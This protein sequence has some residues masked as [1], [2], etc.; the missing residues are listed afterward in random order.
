MDGGEEIHLLTEKRTSC[1]ETAPQ[2]VLSSVGQ[3]VAFLLMLVP[4]LRRQSN[5]TNPTDRP[6]LCR[7]LSSRL[8][9]LKF[10]SLLSNNVYRWETQITSLSTIVVDVDMGSWL[11]DWWFVC[12]THDRKTKGSHFF[13]AWY[14][15]LVWIYSRPISS[16][17]N[18]QTN[19]HLA[20]K[21]LKSDV[22]RLFVWIWFQK[23]GVPRASSTICRDPTLPLFF[24]FLFLLFVHFA[25]LRTFSEVSH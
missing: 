10:A 22:R 20:C 1:G 12:G 24:L 16:L 6:D 4:H 18:K 21:G 5:W 11:V 23:D 19:T 15:H 14:S 7:V 13:A 25:V 2:L 8:L 3:F 17:K 9:F